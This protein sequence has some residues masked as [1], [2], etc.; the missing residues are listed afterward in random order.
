MDIVIVPIVGASEL[1]TLTL[2]VLAPTAAKAADC[3]PSS[4]T[5]S[6]YILDGGIWC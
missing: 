1:A 2:L 4:S 5:T 3:D 6:S